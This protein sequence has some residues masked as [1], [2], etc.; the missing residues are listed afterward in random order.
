MIVSKYLQIFSNLSLIHWRGFMR[1]AK[2]KYKDQHLI[3]LCIAELKHY[4]P[5]F[6]ITQKSLYSKIY[7]S[8][9]YNRKKISQ[10]LL[11][12][13]NIGLEFITSISA[14][15][16]KSI[17]QTNQ[18]LKEINA[19]HLHK[20][21]LKKLQGTNSNTLAQLQI[22]HYLAF[23][24]MEQILELG[25]R[26]KEPNLQE[27]HNHLD[28]SYLFE[29]LIVSCLAMNFAKVNKHDYE[30]GF[31]TL[32]IPYLTEN[33]TEKDKLLYAFLHAFIFISRDSE[34][35]F[36]LVLH[37]IKTEKLNNEE[38][39]RTLF[40]LCINYCIGKINEGHTPYFKS[41]FDLYQYQI[42]SK[43]I[44]DKT[45]KLSA[46]S[47]KNIVTV[48][49]RIGELKWAEKFTSAQSPYLEE[50]NKIDTI[51][52]TMAKILFAQKDYTACLKRLANSKP[53]DFLDNLSMRVLQIKS[54]YSIDDKESAS[55]AL[56]NF[57][58]YLTR[59]RNKGYHYKLHQNFIKILKKYNHLNMHDKASK[60]IIK[61]WIEK[62]NPLAEKAWLLETIG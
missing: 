3:L 57:S 27:V 8:Q 36:N 43:C 6:E 47:L 59:H 62:T 40:L 60:S 53:N 61:K 45:G 15:Q 42:Q 46:A 33:I 44:Y 1:F 18:F 14:E 56:N 37:F 11:R 49:I 34:S 48:A 9:D 51:N 26:S 12:L 20:K 25:I 21:N 22:D 17:I 30:L 19:T 50:R 16:S 13:Q 28:R 39:V 55:F 4:Y 24:K 32:I 41:L 5:T 10:I 52:L 31:I 23:E 58:I 35:S 38:S 7:P 29:K 54:F 2:K